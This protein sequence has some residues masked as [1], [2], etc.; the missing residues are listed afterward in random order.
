MAS[1]GEIEDAEPPMTQV[2]I[3]VSIEPTVIW[4][5]VRHHIRHTL[6]GVR[7]NAPLLIEIEFACDSAHIFKPLSSA[8]TVREPGSC[9]TH[10]S[11]LHPASG[12]R[13]ETSPRN[14]PPACPHRPQKDRASSCA[15]AR[16]RQE[17]RGGNP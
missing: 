10:E 2:Y 11:T 6:D 1:L 16:V 9:A 7:I 4:S 15:S 17:R 14:N 5:A 12:P 13:H 3:A 8:T